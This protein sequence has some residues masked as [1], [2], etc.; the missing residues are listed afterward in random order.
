MNHSVKEA[1]A[2]SSPA[3]EWPRKLLHLAALAPAFLLPYL[4]RYEAAA[5]ALAA[6]AM[7]VLWLK[8]DKNHQLTRVGER[9]TGGF[10]LY[11]LS[12][13][14]VIL[15]LPYFEAALAVWAVLAVGDSLASIVGRAIGGP[16]LPGQSQK[17]VAGSCAFILA[18][19]PAAFGMLCYGGV[20][21]ALAASYAA[22]T[23]V[24]GGVAEAYSLRRTEEGEVDDDNLRIAIGASIGF[25]IVW[26][27]NQA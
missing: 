27:M 19:G 18:G 15:V 12:I 26:G 25:M 14:L 7:N 23:A 11:P 24:F 10:V 20:E 5:M 16:K 17:T 9:V 13:A 6:V 2:D 22:S 21:M 4:D 1:G 8:F 3:F